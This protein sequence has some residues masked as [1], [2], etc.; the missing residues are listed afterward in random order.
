MNNLWS[1]RLLKKL[2]RIFRASEKRNPKHFP[3]GRVPDGK[4]FS[5]CKCASCALLAINGAP[6]KRVCALWGE[7]MPGYR[8]SFPHEGNEALY[9]VH[10]RCMRSRLQKLTEK[11]VGIFRQARIKRSLNTP[12]YFFFFNCPTIP[13]TAMIQASLGRWS[14]YLLTSIFSISSLFLIPGL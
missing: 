1:F 6:I 2:R 13:L 9:L 8:R 4:Y 7:E 5:G 11:P 3:S 14:I 12:F 10:R